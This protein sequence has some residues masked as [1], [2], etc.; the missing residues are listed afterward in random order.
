M[1][2]HREALVNALWRIYNRPNRPTPW[3]YGG[4]LP[5]DDP[6][7]SE[8]MLREHLDQSHNAATR[9]AEQ[10][11]I[12]FNWLWEKLGLAS[13]QHLLD[14]TCGPGLYAVPMAQR[15]VTVTGYDFGPAALNYARELATKEGVA[16]NCTF[17]LQDVRTLDLSANRFDA[18]IL[19]Y[20]QLAVMKKSEA[21]ALLA[22]IAHSLK[23]G[24][25]LMVELLDPQHVDK[26]NSTWWFTDDT[27]LWGD[28]PYLHLGER[29]WVEDQQLSAERFHILH[30]ETGQMDEITLIDQTYTVDAMSTM[31][32]QAGFAG[33]AALPDSAGLPLYDATEWIYYL[34]TKAD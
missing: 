24:G 30:L 26:K 22:M 2:E 33:V 16:E 21:Q 31:L 1:S 29:F 15:G 23:P 12:L 9:V 34:A 25:K 13:G 8:R 11:T 3:A 5:W 6:D 20:G 10:R 18:A 7:F 19:L 27:G 4:N 14:V 28:E 17:I 32:H